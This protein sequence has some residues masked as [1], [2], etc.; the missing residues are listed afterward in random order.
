MTT[1][2]AVVEHGVV[3][4]L[5][6]EVPVHVPGH[7]S[8]VEPAAEKVPSSQSSTT[9]SSVV[10][11]G[12]VMRF[13][14]EVPVHVPGHAAVV[15]PAAEKVPSSQSSTTASSVVEHGVVMR[16]PAEVPVHS[17]GHAVDTSVLNKEGVLSPE[18]VSDPH[19]VQVRSAVGVA[20]A[21]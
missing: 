6:A 3:M 1:A 14:A 10:E 4:R 17:L 16:F 9:A 20:G 19:G 12:V 15:V 21:E 8:V 13:P 2:L 11:H 7:A 18:Y 5:P